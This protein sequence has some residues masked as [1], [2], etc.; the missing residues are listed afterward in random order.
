MQCVG[1]RQRI[2][3]LDQMDGIGVTN[4]GAADGLDEIEGGGPA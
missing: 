1:D 2:E 3:Q 4:R